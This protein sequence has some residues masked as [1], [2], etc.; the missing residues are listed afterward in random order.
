M[1]RAFLLVL[2]YFIVPFSTG[3][4]P[5]RNMTPKQIVDSPASFH[6]SEN[7]YPVAS[8][9]IA[10]WLNDPAWCD[11]FNDGNGKSLQWLLDIEG[12]SIPADDLGSPRV[13]FD[14]LDIEIARWQDLDGFTQSWSGWKNPRTGDRYAMT[15][16]SG[17]DPVEHGEL[18][19]IARHQDQFR[20]AAHGGMP[21]TTPFELDATFTFMKITVIGNAT[22]DEKSLQQRLD[23]ALPDNDLILSTFEREEVGD[24][25][26]ARAT[27]VPPQ[28]DNK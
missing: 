27:F 15:Y 8:A 25:K 10:G 12:A 11:K 28:P 22:D 23:D 2:L 20:I 21:N 3:C 17:H 5:C 6:F 26:L 13:S 19:V 16:H 1:F 24:R 7:E 14:G 9:T 4:D 18:S